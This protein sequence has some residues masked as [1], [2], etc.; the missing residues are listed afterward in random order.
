MKIGTKSLLFGVHQFVLH[1]LFVWVSWRKLFGRPTWGELLAI[2]IHDWGYWGCPNM[3]GEEG[4]QHPEWA[5]RFFMN[6]RMHREAELCRY[7]SRFYA[8]KHDARLSKLCYADKLG[9]AIQPWWL[10]YGVAL[11]SGERYEYI[12]HAQHEIDDL[13]GKRF[14]YHYRGLVKKLFETS[15]NTSVATFGR[16]WCP[17]HLPFEGELKAS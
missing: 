10:W 17:N 4:E 14:F 1:P 2:V 16:K 3:N 13:D 15:D 9:N 5:Y 8:K 6:R 7:H 11:I 12:G